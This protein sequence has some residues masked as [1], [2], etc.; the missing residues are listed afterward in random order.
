MRPLSYLQRGPTFRKPA[1]PVVT[2]R[3]DGRGAARRGS[4]ATA[5]T[6]IANSP[7]QSYRDRPTVPCCIAA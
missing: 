3:E 2:I 7:V 6:A 4:P 1:P 5:R